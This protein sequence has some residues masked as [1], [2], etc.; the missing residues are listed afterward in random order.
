[1]KLNRIVNIFL[2]ISLIVVVFQKNNLRS[3]LKD[4]SQTDQLE[5]D[6]K[7]EKLKVENIELEKDKQAFLRLIEAYEKDLDMKE[8]TIRKLIEENSKLK[9]RA[10]AVASIGVEPDSLDENRIEIEQG[11]WGHR[12]FKGTIPEEGWEPW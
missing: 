5:T 2:A 7:I 10:V 6:K 1:M 8:S 3:Q 4:Q 12:K 11:T 9:S